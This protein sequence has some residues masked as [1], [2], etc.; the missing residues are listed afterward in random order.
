V[1]TKITLEGAK[2]V[3]MAK[4][5]MSADVLIRQDVSAEELIDAILGNRVY[6]PSVVVV[7][8]MD[9]APHIKLPEGYIPISAS[10]KQ[11]L[12][13]LR[14]AIFSKLNFIRIHMKPQGGK[15]D[16][17]EPL[18]LHSGSTIRDL[19]GRLHKEFL[20]KFRY[21]LVWGDSVKH[22]GQRCGLNHTLKDK[23]TVTIV[24]EL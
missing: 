23:D 10:N 7:N 19:C 16:Y 6:I 14:E 12:Q 21:A 22:E 17:S 4:G 1:L 18:I 24:R 3:L 2:A 9:I 8:K 15:A 5:V 11:N 13:A 20:T